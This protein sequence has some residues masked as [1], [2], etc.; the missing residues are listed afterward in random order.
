VVLCQEDFL[1][2]PPAAAGPSDGGS[3][4]GDQTRKEVWKLL[5]RKDLAA[6]SK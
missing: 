6:A 4:G 1:Q 2:Q 5:S 3:G